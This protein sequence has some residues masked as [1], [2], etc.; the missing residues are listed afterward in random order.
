LTLAPFR[1]QATY[2]QVF[3]AL[4]EW[5]VASAIGE[6]LIVQR[7]F[8]EKLAAGKLELNARLTSEATVGVSA[9]VQRSLLTNRLSTSIMLQAAFKTVR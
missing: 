9:K 6:R 8:A 2:G 4:R 3:W 5:L 1:Q 7:P